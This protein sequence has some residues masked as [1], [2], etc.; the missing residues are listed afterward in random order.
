[1]ARAPL[2]SAMPVSVSSSSPRASDAHRV[3]TQTAVLDEQ[4]VE[5]TDEPPSQVLLVGLLG[6]DALPRLAEVVD[7]AS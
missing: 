4:V 7:E 1:M 5:L 3:I 6:D 2:T